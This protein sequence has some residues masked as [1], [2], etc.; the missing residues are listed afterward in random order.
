MITF[1]IL[2]SIISK[3]ASSAEY[4]LIETK[5]WCVFSKFR[6]NTTARGC[7]FQ[8]DMAEAKGWTGLFLTCKFQFVALYQQKKER[9]CCILF[10]AKLA[11]HELF[12]ENKED[13]LQMQTKITSDNK[14]LFVT[15][16]YWTSHSSVSFFGP[17]WALLGSA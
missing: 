15:V 12:S 8:W 5:L 4:L 2:H 1:T 14:N 3:A 17:F 11:N 9:G 16:L 13:S 7:F 6:N 10:S